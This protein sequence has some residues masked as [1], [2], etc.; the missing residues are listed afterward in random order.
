ME[1]A[2]TVI[3]LPRG[4]WSYDE[5]APLG[6][7]GG[8]GIV[9]AGEGRDI[10]P[11]AVK[12]LKVSADD[13]AHRELRIANEL[14]GNV[15]AHI[16]PMYDAG[17]DADSGA[18]FVVMARAERS[19]LDELKTRK[20][21][22]DKSAMGILLQIGQ[23]LAEVGQLVHRDLKPGNV[24]YH[25]GVWKVADFGIARFVEESTSPNTLKDCLSRQYAA[26]E[27]FRL[28][29]ASGATDVY[30]LGCIGYALLT[31]KPP[32]PGPL[33]EDYSR[34]HQHDEPPSLDGHDGR[35]RSILSMM[36][37]KTADARPSVARVI[38]QL[39]RAVAESPPSGGLAA[40]A[41]AGAA[42]A[43]RE[44][45][46]D[47]RQSAAQSLK[48]SREQL[49]KDAE[50]LLRS[51]LTD[52]FDRIV[53]A[54]PPAKRLSNG[55]GVRL[56]EAELQVWLLGKAL[57]ADSFP[58]SQWEV[59]TGAKIWVRQPSPK[60]EWSASLW[61]A[62]LKPSD[63]YRWHEISYFVNPLARS[64]RGQHECAPF[65]L[66]EDIHH[67]DEAAGPALTTYCTAW[68]PEP[69][70]DENADAFFHRWADLLAKAAQGQISYP[71]NL[72]LR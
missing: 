12:R 44:G 71:R 18:Y 22:D 6:P 34:Q 14:A 31:G 48:V 43:R 10:G 50:K 66:T 29:R 16:I 27:Q 45:S 56:G 70:D 39:S 32:F 33:L 46:D 11:V 8:F 13:A 9:F 19:L 51:L 41:E 55:L 68:G 23:G 4:Q 47:A 15:H 20:M 62:R 49:A 58:Q 7:A 37:R 72:P 1:N 2:V 61:Y 35:L 40:L 24:L 36:L 69:I 5:N 3:K 59:V 64:A 53:A 63:D 60:Y 38:A 52:V 65:A 67:A 17:E 57:P 25:G 28:E 54:A 30:A 26:P 42:V 21:F